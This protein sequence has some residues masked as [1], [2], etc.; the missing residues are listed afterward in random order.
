MGRE[1]RN[2]N[3]KFRP[4]IWRWTG[5]PLCKIGSADRCGQRSCIVWKRSRCNSANGKH[6]KD[7]DVYHRAGVSERTSGPDG[8]GIGSGCV[9]A[10]GASGN[11][12]RRSIL[13]KRSAVFSDVGIAQW[14]CGSSGRRSCW[15]CRKI[16]REN[17]CKSGRDRLQGHAFYYTERAGC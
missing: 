7:Y 14:Q 1:C 8:R 15:K 16:C 12:E 10:E 4:D 9:T 13:S 2:C 11:A 3:T 17:E 5:K 6:N